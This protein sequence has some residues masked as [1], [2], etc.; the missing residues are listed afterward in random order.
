MMKINASLL[1]ACL[2][3]NSLDVHEKILTQ[4]RRKHKQTLVQ[5]RVQTADTMQDQHI[6][7]NDA[8]STLDFNDLCFRLNL[9]RFS[10]ELFVALL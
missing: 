2:P 5:S 8:S 4:Y 1:G 9:K 10:L 6:T 7:G 3:V